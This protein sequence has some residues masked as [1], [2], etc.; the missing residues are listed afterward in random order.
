MICMFMILYVP[1]L[2]GYYEYARFV[3]FNNKQKNKINM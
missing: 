1:I 3:L 2:T